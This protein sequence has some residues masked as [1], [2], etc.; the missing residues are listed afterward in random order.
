MIRAR[1]IPD[2]NNSQSKNIKELFLYGPTSI[3]SFIRSLAREI[4]GEDRIADTLLGEDGEF[5]KGVKTNQDR[6]QIFSV[7]D[8]LKLVEI[9]KIIDPDFFTMRDAYRFLVRDKINSYGR[10]LKKAKQDS[11]KIPS[12]KKHQRLSLSNYNITSYFKKIIRPR[13]QQE[14]ETSE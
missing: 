13:A 14:K 9:L 7:D 10:D 1:E 3:G 6:D 2:V 8:E 11:D 12:S 5:L 4:F